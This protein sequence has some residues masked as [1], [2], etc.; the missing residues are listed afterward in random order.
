MSRIVSPTMV[1]YRAELGGIIGPLGL[2]S[3]ERLPLI[4]TSNP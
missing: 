2:H 1:T 4:A 3:L